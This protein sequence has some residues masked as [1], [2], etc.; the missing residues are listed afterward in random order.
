MAVAQVPSELSYG[1]PASRARVMTWRR[2]LAGAFVA[3]ALAIWLDSSRPPNQQFFVRTSVF[4]IHVYQH[5]GSVVLERAGFQCR[6]QPTC[7]HYGVLALEKFGF[8]RGTAL[9]AGRILRCRP[10]T[11]MGTIDVP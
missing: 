2:A 3:V 11:P 5:T 1:G 6:F 8:L 10:G 9:T 7:S 4:A